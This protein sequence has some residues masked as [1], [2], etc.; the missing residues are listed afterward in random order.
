MKFTDEEIAENVREGKINVLTLDTSV[1]DSE[2]NRF[3][4]GLLA[5]LRQFKNSEIQLVL[6]E[7]VRREV[8]AHV[9]KSASDE[10]DKLRS[11]MRGIGLTWQVDQ[12]TRDAA[13]KSLFG[14]ESS[15]S[16]AERRV[17][18]FLD[19]C[20]VELVGSEGRVRVEDLLHDYF[21]ASAPFGKTADKKNEFPDA[22]ALRSLEHWASEK[23]RCILVVSKDNDWAAYCAASPRLVCVKDLAAAVGY[24]QQTSTAICVKLCKMLAADGL[25]FNAQIH[26][27]LV[28]AVDSSDFI[29]NAGSAYSFDYDVEEIEVS[30]SQLLEQDD[31][32]ALIVVDRPEE[33][34]IVVAADFVVTYSV[35]TG[36]S[37]A[38]KDGID[39]DMVPI[40]S[41]SEM[42]DV[43]VV[44]RV[45]LTFEDA[46]S[47][48]PELVD[49]EVELPRRYHHVDYGDVSPD[50]DRDWDGGWAEQDNQN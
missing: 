27:A 38:V 15:S 37:F 44:A 2:R 12:K 36:F 9:T 14:E 50:F 13:F 42:A 29:P 33:D 46:R 8:Q 17:C 23:D 19:D 49:V 7:V 11:A 45:L 41:T 5:R 20:G 39:K 16:F 10:Q 34:V 43:E 31:D 35:T 18:Q 22:I 48:A 47:D 4:H 40:G 6:A 1:F 25:D 21:S 24:F 30:D 3:E 26:T 32:R 28:G